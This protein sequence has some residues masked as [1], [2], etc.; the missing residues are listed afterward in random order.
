MRLVLGAARHI[1][2]CTKTPESS[3]LYRDLTCLSHLYDPAGHKV[4]AVFWEQF[5]L[6][7][8]R[9]NYTFQGQE[10]GEEP[11]MAWV[12]FA[13]QLAVMIPPPTERAF[14]N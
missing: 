12:H 1:D 2:L 3:S 13:G 4:M 10:M 9:T 7:E 5:S 11:P 6:W 8:Q 14:G